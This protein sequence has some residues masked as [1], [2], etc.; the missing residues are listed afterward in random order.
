VQGGRAGVRAALY[1]AALTATRY[2]PTIAAFYRRLVAAGKPKQLALVACM[3]K[4]LTTLNAI[5][6]TGAP[7]RADPT[8]VRP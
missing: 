8:V 5:A 7:W 1:M 3:R 4:L 2:N 6:R